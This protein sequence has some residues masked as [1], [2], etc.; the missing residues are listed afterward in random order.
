MNAGAGDYHLQITSLGIDFA[1]S[2]PDNRPAPTIDLD[3]MPRVFDLPS[4]PNTYGPRDF[5][6]YEHF[7]PCYRLGTMFCDGFDANY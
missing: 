6:A 7:P 1:I 3:A 2:P 4:I 5:G